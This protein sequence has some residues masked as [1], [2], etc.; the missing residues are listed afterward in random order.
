[1]ARIKGDTFIA[2]ERGLMATLSAHGLHPF[3]VQNDRRAWDVFHRA[4]Q[5]GRIDGKALYR[6]YNDAHIQ[7]ALRA[8]F[9]R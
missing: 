8:I 9:K 1:M 6:D 5:E 2:L 4:W 7:T 3:M